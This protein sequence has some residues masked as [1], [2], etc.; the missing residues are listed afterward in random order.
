MPIP[1]SL[2]GRLT[3]PVIG[4]P[5]F[6]VSGPELVIAQCKAGVVGSFPALNARPKEQ[7]DVWITRIK[8]ELEEYRAQNPGARVAP[9]AVNQI[10]HRSNDRLEHDMEV[11]VRHEVPI[12]I[13]SLRPPAEVVKAVHSY[14]GIVLHDV[15]NVRHA[16]KALEEGVDG[17]I[18]VCAGAG[19]HAGM[20]S[21]FALVAEVRKFYQ[22]TVC[23]A[24]AIS[25]GRDVLTAQSIG[26]DL[27]YVGT[28]FIATEEA[29]AMPD[30]KQMLIDT[31]AKDI[32][33]SSLFTGV[34][35]NYLKPSVAAAGFDADN[36]PSADKSTMNFNSGGNMAAKAWRD[37]WS[38]GQGVGSI[39][40]APRVET[41]IRRMRA[42][43]DA[44]Y[45]DITSRTSAFRG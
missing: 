3:L 6:I 26:A 37:I 28:R 11:C 45:D 38:A 30:Y 19:G 17:L 35:G 44:A 43:Y 12:I 22:G 27:A 29:N 14:G 36:L 39:T 40:D 9:F 34:H 15:I 13:T 33:Y 21:P 1:K 8:T 23:L 7:L 4:A 32:V 5:M 24:G 31:T 25:T 16:E 20:L 18:L 42:E 41:L 10:A 2:E